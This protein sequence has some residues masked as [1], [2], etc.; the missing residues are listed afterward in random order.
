MREPIDNEF[1]GT[2]TSNS[3]ATTPASG[4]SIGSF[5]QSG[6]GVIG[7]GVSSYFNYKNAREER[8]F[9]KSLL[10]EQR[11]Q[12]LAD[13]QHEEEYNSPAAQL[14][15]LRLAGISPTQLG[16]VSEQHSGDMSVHGDP[17]ALVAATSAQ[18]AALGQGFASAIDALRLRK[19]SAEIDKIYSDI[20]KTFSDK[21]LNA[22]NL[23]YLTS[24]LSDRLQQ[25]RFKAISSEMSLQEL[26]ASIAN[27]Q[28]RTDLT[29]SQR[30]QVAQA[31]NLA[32]ATFADS[33]RLSKFQ[34]D[35]AE[36]DAKIKDFD[37][38][39]TLPA[40]LSRIYAQTA[41]IRQGTY[42]D[43]QRLLLEMDRVNA[44]VGVLD[45]QSKSLK[46]GN[47]SMQDT[48][49]D[50]VDSLRAQYG[51]TE[52]E[53]KFAAAQQWMKIVTGFGAAVGVTVGTAL[54]LK[55]RGAKQPSKG[56]VNSNDFMDV[57]DVMW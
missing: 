22:I 9:Q 39:K 6:L 5:I 52:T 17:S 54:G 37:L 4:S 35:N 56:R 38:T 49:D 51:M 26:S 36:L 21:E 41:S 2:L 57:P 27:L 10:D 28:A 47:K 42:N 20:S 32:K 13:R 1:T 53:A 19:Q 50:Y 14:M 12:S 7:A 40:E 16:D 8:K 44:Y 55:G 15:R 24:S 46:F 25:E 48:Y 33:V 34:A 45:E 29:K 43:Y 23:E 18:Q 11:K 3:V 31:L 30:E